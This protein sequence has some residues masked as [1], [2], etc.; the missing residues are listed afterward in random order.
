MGQL[1]SGYWLVV[2][3]LV[4]LTAAGMDS[5]VRS[6]PELADTPMR[7][8]F[9]TW[10]LPCLVTVAAASVVP[11]MAGDPRAWILSLAIFSALLLIVVTAG[12]G[13]LLQGAPWHRGARLGLNVATYLAAFALYYRI[14]GMQVRSLMS[15]TAVVLITFPLALELLRGTAEDVETTWLYAAVVA[16]VVG[17][18]MWVLNAWGLNALQ[19]GSLLL[20]LFYTFG[21]ISQQHMA[22]RLSRRVVLEFVVVGLVGLAAVWASSSWLHG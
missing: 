4:L 15:A 22:G 8:T 11:N 13:T 5:L 14:Y 6:L 2:T 16:L 12:Y 20:V 3:L 18:L 1:L 21:G 19:G 7:Y 9:T 10:V 17:Q